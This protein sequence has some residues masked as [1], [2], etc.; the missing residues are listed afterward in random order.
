MYSCD[1]DLVEMRIVK[2]LENCSIS[3]CFPVHFLEY[4]RTLRV[5]ICRLWYD[6]IA[7][8]HNG[9]DG[10]TGNDGQNGDLEYDKIPTMA[11]FITLK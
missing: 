10:I 2:K 3:F 11:V 1:C 7:V 6:H 5:V 9:E 4:A 8:H